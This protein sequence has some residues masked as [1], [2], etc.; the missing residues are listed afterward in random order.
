M[1]LWKK[2]FGDRITSLESNPERK[3][4]KTENNLEVKK[5]MWQQ[6]PKSDNHIEK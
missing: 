5:T 4:D 3:Y 1:V 2:I 6:R